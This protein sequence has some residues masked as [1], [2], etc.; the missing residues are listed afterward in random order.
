VVG[1]P[2]PAVTWGLIVA[3]GLILGSLPVFVGLAIT[4]PVLG[5]A[6]WH[7]YRKLVSV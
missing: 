5:H 3:L 1:N 2:V 7:V 6:T 4:L